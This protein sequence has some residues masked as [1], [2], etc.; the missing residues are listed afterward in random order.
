MAKHPRNQL[1]RIE[2]TQSFTESAKTDTMQCNDLKAWYL[3][4]A[5]VNMIRKK[6]KFICKSSLK[7]NTHSRTTWVK[8]LLM[9]ILQRFVYDIHIPYFILNIILFFCLFFGNFYKIFWKKITSKDFSV[10]NLEITWEFLT[11]I[12]II[13][14]YYWIPRVHIYF[15]ISW[16][17]TP[18][19]Y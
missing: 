1:N 9:H 13:L 18:S 3:I 10:V 11:C 16:K 19:K 17:N 8:N 2:C 6:T 7:W 5:K 15:L 4:V 12:I 14:S